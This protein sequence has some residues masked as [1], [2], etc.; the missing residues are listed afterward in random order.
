[1][2]KEGKVKK[3]FEIDAF[4][5]EFPE[6]R[7]VLDIVM[8]RDPSAGATRYMDPVSVITGTSACARRWSTP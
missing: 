5:S 1:M 3:I 4:C 8:G 6:R 7:L 2:G